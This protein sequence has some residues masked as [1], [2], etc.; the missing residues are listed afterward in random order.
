MLKKTKNLSAKTI[1]S[2]L[3]L[4]LGVYG[5]TF[6][7]VIGMLIY[8]A[9]SH[10]FQPPVNDI[11]VF[12]FI[13]NPAFL[14]DINHTADISGFLGSLSLFRAALWIKAFYTISQVISMLS[15]LYSVVL[16][17]KIVKTVI[18]G[19]PFIPK[20]G[21]RLKVVALITII[22]PLVLQISTF[23]V[24]GHITRQLY[25]AEMTVSPSLMGMGSIGTSTY[26]LAGGF[27]FVISEVFRI[28]TSLKEE[29]DLTV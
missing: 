1:Y 28:G 18:E 4:T 3:S 16:L 14:Q 2:F 23:F 24:T 22:V 20:N 13:R 15:V 17:R 26:L 9:F 21:K 10:N 6:M 5:A 11:P 8:S 7:V 29:Q 12:I 19:N 27:I 25:F